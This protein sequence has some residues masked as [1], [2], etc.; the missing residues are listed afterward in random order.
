MALALLRLRDTNG[1]G[2]IGIDDF[3]FEIHKSGE[4]ILCL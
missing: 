1:D 3:Y 4:G 2:M